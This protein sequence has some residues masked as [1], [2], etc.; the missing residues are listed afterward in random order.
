MLLLLLLT[1]LPHPKHK[2]IHHVCSCTVTNGLYSSDCSSLAIDCIL[3]NASCFKTS[4]KSIRRYSNDC[5]FYVGDCD[6]IC[7]SSCS[8]D[9]SS[10]YQYT[11]SI[12]LWFL[13][14]SPFQ[15]DI[16]PF[17][18]IL[19]Y[20]TLSKKTITSVRKQLSNILASSDPTLIYLQMNLF[21]S[22]DWSSL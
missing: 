18:L 16:M 21:Y 7:L 6:S 13:D 8:S 5:F 15:S 17:Y 20:F 11:Q 22:S 2:C 14:W 1:I 4:K 12:H 9:C 10:L 3:L 19:R